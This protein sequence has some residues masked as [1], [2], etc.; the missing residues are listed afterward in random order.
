MG[1]RTEKLTTRQLERLSKELPE[2]EEVW[3]AELSGY[4]IRAGKRG[5]A[6]RVSYYNSATGQRRVLT[7]GRYGKL[8]ASQGREAAKEALAVIV[9]GGDPRAIQESAKEVSSPM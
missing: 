2:G 4:H 9:Q 7:V 1:K 3:D 5:L 6:M 8:T